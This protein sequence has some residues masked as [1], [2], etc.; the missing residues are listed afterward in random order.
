MIGV[1]SSLYSGR[2]P[3]LSVLNRQATS[4]LPKFAAVIWSSGEYRLP[5]ASP[6]YAGHSPFFVVGEKPAAVWPESR[7]AT[8]ARAMTSAVKG[9]VN[10]AILRDILS[11]VWL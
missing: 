10:R 7:T 9:T 2:V 6:V 11:S 5:L 4:S 1:P 8:A 3:R